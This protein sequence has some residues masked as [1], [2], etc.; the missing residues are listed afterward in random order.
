MRPVVDAWMTL[1]SD[2]YPTA[3]RNKFNFDINLEIKLHVV[4]V[5]DLCHPG[6]RA[7]LV[8]GI[9]QANYETR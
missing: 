1:N 6:P 2:S 8:S 5:P 7:P 3:V 9:N 4:P